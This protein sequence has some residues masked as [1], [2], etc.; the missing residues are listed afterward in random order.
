MDVR[1][2]GSHAGGRM[3]GD[4]APFRRAVDYKKHIADVGGLENRTGD[5]GFLDERCDIEQAGKLEATAHAAKVT[6]LGSE[7][8]LFGD[9]SAIGGGRERRNLGVT[10]RRG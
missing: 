3:Q 9:P 7:V 1:P 2:R 10:Q 4:L 8:L 6:N 5:S